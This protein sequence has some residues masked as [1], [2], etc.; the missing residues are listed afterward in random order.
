[1]HTKAAS[2][3]SHQNL[4]WFDRCICLSHSNIYSLVP[5]DLWSQALANKPTRSNLSPSHRSQHWIHFHTLKH[6]HSLRNQRWSCTVCICDLHT[7][8]YSHSRSQLSTSR[9]VGVGA[10]IVWSRFWGHRT[11][12]AS[13]GYQTQDKIQHRTCPRCNQS[14]FGKLK[15]SPR[16]LGSLC[17]R[18]PS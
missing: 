16:S 15:A 2:R 11:T 14:D 12:R 9:L 13:T 17:K 6:Y 10:C 1:M 4:M 3:I 7:L 5:S 8:N 18:P